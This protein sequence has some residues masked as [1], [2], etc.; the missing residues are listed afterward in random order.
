MS[1]RRRTRGSRGGSSLV[2]VMVAVTLLGVVVA[3]TAGMTTYVGR[4]SALNAQLT[5]RAAVLARESDR[6]LTMPY[7]SLPSNATCTADS[8]PAF[9]HTRCITITE[10]AG[11]RGYRNVRLI[12]TPSQPTLRADTVMVQRTRAVAVSPLR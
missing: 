1:Q 11:G 10:V 6:L 7:D 12:V 5:A 3:G 2:E 8:L 9:P 4:R